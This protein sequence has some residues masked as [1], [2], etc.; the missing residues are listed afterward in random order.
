MWCPYCIVVSWLNGCIF[1]CVYVSVSAYLYLHFMAM[2]MTV[3]MIR[4]APVPHQCITVCTS[5]ST[6]HTRDILSYYICIST[7]FFAGKSL[8]ITFNKQ[9]LTPFFLVYQNIGSCCYFGFVF[10]FV[11]FL[12]VTCSAG[13]I[14]IGVFTLYLYLYLWMLKTR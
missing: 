8:M 2:E 10:V 6:W 13:D 4:A 14:F 12:V 11:S 7:C 5:S 3:I 1:P 9:S